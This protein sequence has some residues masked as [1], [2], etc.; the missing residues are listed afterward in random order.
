[1]RATIESTLDLAAEVGADCVY[2]IT[3][4]RKA[5]AWRDAVEIFKEEF[6]PSS[7]VLA[8]ERGLRLAIEPHPS[9]PPRPQ[10]PEYGARRRQG[11]DRDRRPQRRLRLRFLAPLVGARHPGDHRR[12]RAAHLQRP[13]Q[14]P[15]TKD[16][17]VPGPHRSR[18]GPDP[19]RRPD[20]RARSPRAT[21]ATTRPRSSP[22]TTAKW[23]TTR[24]S[25]A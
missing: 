25:T 24:P 7:R 6:A 19:L 21:T 9:P 16:Y 18:R 20:W 2:V 14:R 13:G 23:A 1:M 5:S 8:R 11:R 12:D 10:L 17:A 15:Q 3:G 22:T 4:G